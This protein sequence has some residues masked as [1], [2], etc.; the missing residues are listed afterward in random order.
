MLRTANC[1]YNTDYQA[2]SCDVELAINK[3]TRI[4]VIIYTMDDLLNISNSYYTT[5]YQQLHANKTISNHKE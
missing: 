2:T 1:N 3:Q 4:Q 5:F